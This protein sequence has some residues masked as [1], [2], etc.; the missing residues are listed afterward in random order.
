VNIKLKTG[1]KRLSEA[2]NNPSLLGSALVSIHGALEDHFRARLANNRN[3]TASERITIADRQ[4]T[5]W[6][7]LLD[8]LE[9]HQNLTP[10]ERKKILRFNNLRQG[11]AHGDEFEGTADEVEEYAN[12]V[13]SV[14][15]G[16]SI[17]QVALTPESPNLQYLGKVLCP[18]GSKC[19]GASS[20]SGPPACY[21]SYSG[22]S[23]PS[24]FLRRE[25]AK[26][27]GFGGKMVLSIAVGLIEAFSEVI[28]E[29]YQCSVCGCE[30]LF[31]H[32]QTSHGWNVTRVGDIT[33]C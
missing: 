31:V 13:Q 20:F 6:I 11:F 28:Y 14:V 4:K 17:S 1:L 26:E 21:Q 12:Y 15:E 8:L 24:R 7:Q 32:Y 9:Q 16:N 3:L 22:D 23:M 19:R 33:S 25:L 30:V 5:Q 29:A 2:R 10:G 18:C 27:K